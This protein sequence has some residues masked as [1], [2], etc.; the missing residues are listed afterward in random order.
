MSH[1]APGSSR[2]GPRC[3][4]KYLMRVFRRV[5]RAAEDFRNRARARANS[6][7]ELPGAV[8]SVGSALGFEETGDGATLDAFG[9][10]QKLSVAKSS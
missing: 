1:S 6:P 7:S 2:S 3:V 10:A 8:I 9:N 5:G 4:I